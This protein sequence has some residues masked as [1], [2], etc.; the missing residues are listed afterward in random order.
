MAEQ[1]E[2]KSYIEAGDFFIPK[3]DNPW[4]K[5]GSLSLQ[6]LGKGME[7]FAQGMNG[8]YGGNP[9]KGFA[10]FGEGVSEGLRKRRK[11][12]EEAQ[13]EQEAADRQK[14]EQETI[15]P[16]DNTQNA[17]ANAWYN[18]ANKFWRMG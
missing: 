18:Y 10:D 17:T 3:T 8:N 2:E 14:Q 11:D 13:R 15:K 7:N 4:V 9:G 5:W 6:G 1:N 16:I 12:A